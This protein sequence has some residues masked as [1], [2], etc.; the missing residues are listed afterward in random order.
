MYGTYSDLDHTHR[1]S[2][3]H[4]AKEIE[5]TPTMAYSEPQAKARVASLT[6]PSYTT[7]PFPLPPTVDRRSGPESTRLNPIPPGG[8][9]GEKI[10]DA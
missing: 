5:P 10:D 6:G 4:A 1:L 9:G 2:N 8:G 7:P 3:S